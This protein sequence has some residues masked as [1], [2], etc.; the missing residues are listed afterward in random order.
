M[1]SKRAIP[2]KLPTRIPFES[3]QVMRPVSSIETQYTFQKSG[4][5]L[6]YKN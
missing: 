3:D 4:A 1:D 2:A 5:A 6:P